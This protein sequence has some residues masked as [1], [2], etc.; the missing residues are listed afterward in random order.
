LTTPFLQ[1]IFRNEPGDQYL[2]AVSRLMQN[3]F[4][5]ADEQPA[6]VP[7]EAASETSESTES[8]IDA[9]DSSKASSRRSTITDRPATLPFLSLASFRMVVLADELLESFFS[10]DLTNAWHLEPLTEDVPA[11]K[12][13]GLITGRLTN[14][15]SSFITDEN[16]EYLG[17]LADDIGKRLDIQQIEQKPAL[18]R[19]TGAAALQEPLER[20]TLLSTSKGAH[21]SPMMTSSPFSAASMRQPVLAP[22]KSASQPTTMVPQ[23]S[24]VEEVT[25][26][27]A[28]PAAIAA[29]AEREIV[30]KALP[31]APK[32]QILGLG[33]MDERPRFAI[34]DAGD[35]DDGEEDDGA[36]IG[37]DDSGLMNGK[38]HGMYQSHAL[39][40]SL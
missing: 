2:A 16:K 15:V 12:Q 35:E 20:A 22:P 28:T 4:E 30:N 25:S 7:H 9:D 14:F 40:D 36:L 39:T 18:G 17:K 19:L 6:P 1:F 11:P 21:T 34:D 5:Y 38:P 33:I 32:D 3:A 29:A 13:T 31:N 26:P 8:L 24:P 27:S 10:E 37:D 23:I